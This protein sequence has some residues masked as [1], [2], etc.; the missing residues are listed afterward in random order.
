LDDERNYRDL[1]K[2]IGVINP[3]TENEIREK[4]EHFEDPTGSIPKFHYGTHYSNPAGVM[5]FLIRMEPFTT[6]H[7]QLQGGRF[8]MADRQ[9]HSISS[10]WQ[11]QT[12]NANDVKEL[13][14]E[15]FY[16][17]EFLENLNGWSHDKIVLG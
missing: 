3:K 17:P 16:L 7:I 4:Y 12:E 1:S 5:H 15:F 8:D 10:T 6:L 2:P 13:I 11:S 9:F 14:P